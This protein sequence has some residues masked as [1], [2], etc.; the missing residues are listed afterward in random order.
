[1]T[2]AR[3][4]LHPPD[5]RTPVPNHEGERGARAGSAKHGCHAWVRLRAEGEFGTAGSRILTTLSLRRHTGMGQ[6][7]SRGSKLLGASGDTPF[8][9][10]QVGKAR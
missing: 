4:P 10:R 8:R 2:P 3:K 9:S 7:G 6:W 1:M 5:L